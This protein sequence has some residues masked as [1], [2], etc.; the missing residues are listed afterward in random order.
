MSGPF[1]K[2]AGPVTGPVQPGSV[3]QIGQPQN[4]AFRA[5]GAEKI[6]RAPYGFNLITVPCTHLFIQ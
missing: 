1:D 5:K 2:R 6:A 3:G 4:F